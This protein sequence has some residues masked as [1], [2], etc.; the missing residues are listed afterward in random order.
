MHGMGEAAERLFLL[1]R[2][3]ELIMIM[4]LLV[5]AI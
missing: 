2:A 4:V 1:V 3:L 5:E